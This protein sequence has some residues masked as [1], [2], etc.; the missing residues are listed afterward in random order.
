MALR[1]H[2][3][4]L[5]AGPGCAPCVGQSGALSCPHHPASTPGTGH[6]PHRC[7]DAW[8]YGHRP[9][10]CADA[11][12]F[13]HHPH[14]P[15]GTQ[16]TRHRSRCPGSAQGEGCC[17]PAP[18]SRDAQP[19]PR[20]PWVPS[21][22]DLSPVWRAKRGAAQHTPLTVPCP[23]PADNA[24]TQTATM[25]D[26][27][28][29]VKTQSRSTPPS[30]PP[31]P[32]AVTQG[33]TRHPSFTPNTSEYRG[34]GRDAGM[35][36]GCR[37]GG[38]PSSLCLWVTC[39][40]PDQRRPQTPFTVLAVPWGGTTH[41]CTGEGLWAAH[42]KPWLMYV[43]AGTTTALPV[44]SSA[45]RCAWGRGRP[46]LLPRHHR[47]V[48]QSSVWPRVLSPAESRP[49]D[50]AVWGSPHG[51]KL[52]P[53]GG[54]EHVGSCLPIRTRHPVVAGWCHGQPRRQGPS[55]P[56]QATAWWDQGTRCGLAVRVLSVCS[57]VELGKPRR[58]GC[59]GGTWARY[60]PAGLAPG[61]GPCAGVTA[62]AHGK[63][64]HTR[65]RIWGGQRPR[66][67]PPEQE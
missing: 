44:A 21:A 22:P 7:A 53:L 33:A 59:A 28:A 37:D 58:A 4:R 25:P 60:T 49:E 16:D 65:G 50:A 48:A 66:L 26:S 61:I 30:M 27:P 36:T 10:R 62:P 31:P 42:R 54:S 2:T 29:D 34:C 1:G 3:R 6:R 64:R 67:V 40:T 51:S 23:L 19:S 20:S 35:E 55:C 63:T 5:C 57:I 41:S 13:G 32:P 46:G 56:A 43:P 39:C 18:G 15:A 52:A 8:E 9:H 11:R 17:H 24:E 47:T 45:V 38:L 14:R 12:E